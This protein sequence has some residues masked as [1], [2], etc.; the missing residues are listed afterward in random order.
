MEKKKVRN[1]SQSTKMSFLAFA[2]IKLGPQKLRFKTAPLKTRECA[3]KLSKI[4]AFSNS[5]WQNLKTIK[6]IEIDPQKNGD[7]TE[8]ANR[9]VRG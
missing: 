6:N 7:M 4:A 8:K 5:R 3:I 2:I 1:L 9:P